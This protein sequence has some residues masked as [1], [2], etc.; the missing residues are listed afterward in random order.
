MN[1]AVL[2]GCREEQKVKIESFSQKIRCFPK[3]YA[4]QRPA[5]L[6]KDLPFDVSNDSIPRFMD[7]DTIVLVFGT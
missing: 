1:R 6:A 3:R 4:D 5:G 2:L 7:G